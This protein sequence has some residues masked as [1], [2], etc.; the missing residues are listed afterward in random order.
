MSVEMIQNPI[1]SGI[2]YFKNENVLMPNNMNGSEKP[3]FIIK[4]SMKST[5]NGEVPNLALITNAGYER[6]RRE[7]KGDT[8]NLFHQ[9]AKEN[10]NLACVSIGNYGLLNINEL[11]EKPTE[12]SAEETEDLGDDICNTIMK[13]WFERNCSRIESIKIESLRPGQ[14][15]INL[16]PQTVKKET[17]TVADISSSF[18]LWTIREWEGGILAPIILQELRSQILKQSFDEL[19]VCCAGSKDRTG[20]M[21]CAFL[22]LDVVPVILKEFYQQNPSTNLE[23]DLQELEKLTI[24][25]TNF[26]V[27]TIRIHFSP[28]MIEDWAEMG[29]RE[30]IRQDILNF[31]PN[32]EYTPFYEWPGGDLKK[33]F[34][35][36]VQKWFL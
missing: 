16:N 14:K 27:H 3:N 19:I 20:V 15:F 13:D 1:K 4:C 22:A 18:Q 6:H 34:E 11:R 25:I 29:L 33:L 26:L 8:R 31:E 35:D 9:R 24:N 17:F 36:F 28:K 2:N 12:C 7:V 21:F 30:L 32:D 10:K 23:N 5:R